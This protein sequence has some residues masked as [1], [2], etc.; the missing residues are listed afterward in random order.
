[1]KNIKLKLAVL[2]AV[3]VFSAEVFATGLVAIPATG[4]ATSAYTTCHVRNNFG[5]SGNQ[6]PT[7]TVDN[8]CATFPTNEATSPVAGYTLVAT[9]SRPVTMNNI[10]TNNTNVVVGTVLDNVWRNAA[11]TS[12]IYG[13]RLTSANIDYRPLVAGTQWFEVNDIARAGFSASGSVNAGYFIQAAGASPIYRIGRTFTAVQHRAKAYDTA[14]NKALVGT[15]YVALPG[16]GGSVASIN[17]EN[18]PIAAATLA[19]TSAA[20]QTATVNSNWVDFTVDAVFQDDDGS[21]APVSAMTYVE[22]ACDA[23][24]PVAVANA[25]RLRQTAQENANFI[26]VSVSGFTP[27]GGTALPAPVVPF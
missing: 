7:T 15:N 10:Y 23:T 16:L 3:S 18:T 14:A 8:V 17:G 27:P 13:A 2:G 22:A 9:A 21:P 26:E 19:S 24:A 1:M 25:I 5:S 4:F 20:N 12:C 11:K 6:Q